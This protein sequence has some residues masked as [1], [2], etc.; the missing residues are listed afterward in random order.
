MGLL[1][2]VR[3]FRAWLF[4]TNNSLDF[5]LKIRYNYEW[6]LET[7]CRGR[8]STSRLLPAGN[9]DASEITSRVSLHDKTSKY[10][11][12]SVH[13]WQCIYTLL[14]YHA[15]MLYV[16]LYTV[17]QHLKCFKW[18]NKSISRSAIDTRS[19]MSLKPTR[20]QC[21][22]GNIVFSISSARVTWQPPRRRFICVSTTE[23]PGILG[24]P[25]VC[26]WDICRGG[27]GYPT[28]ESRGRNPH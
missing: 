1:Y 10:H 9:W 25:G 5:F 26:Q 2:H 23:V 20:C 24:Q 6:T 8:L 22:A 16:L 7:D 17:H 28:G 21:H 19:R 14:A 13:W 15:R 11:E 27:S 18:A 4:Q 3:T 12:F